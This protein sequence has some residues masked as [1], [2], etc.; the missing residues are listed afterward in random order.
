MSKTQMFRV[1]I[2]ATPEAIWEAITSPDWNDRYGYKSK[3]EY[4]LHGGGD[5]RTFATE[6]MRTFGMPEIV[7]DG[8]VREADPPKKLVHTFH[9][10]FSPEQAAEPGIV[11]TY[12]IEPEDNGGLTRLTIVTDEN[13]SPAT[14]SIVTGGEGKLT[15]GGGGFPF[16]LSDLKSL[17][18]SG[19]SLQD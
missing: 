1:Y 13:N 18:E 4:E 9:A 11:V 5:Y 8:E 3:S 6:E 2:K 7:I 14:L 12:L 15:E 10:F 19:Q 16:I 17:L